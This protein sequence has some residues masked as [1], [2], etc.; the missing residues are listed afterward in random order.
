MQMPGNL[1]VAPGAIP[2]GIATYAQPSVNV[3]I[4]SPKPQ[5]RLQSGGWL[6][7][8]FLAAIGVLLACFLFYIGVWLLGET[9]TLPAKVEQGTMESLAKK[10]ALEALRT[11]G[12]RALADEAIAGEYMGQ[13]IVTGPA[14]SE[15]NRI[16]NVSVIFQVATVN[17]TRKWQLVNARVD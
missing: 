1:I 16:V 5:P 2:N 13:W 8:A 9:L 10:H 12:V 7:R 14:M 17:G 3:L 11:H 6:T 15:D 4:S